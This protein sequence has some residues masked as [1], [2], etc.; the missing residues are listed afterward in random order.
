MQVY[1]ISQELFGSV[2]FPGN[3]VP[4]HRALK[5]MEDGQAANLSEISL[6]THNGTHVDA[7]RHF[8]SDG[9]TIDRMDLNRLVGPCSVI[10]FE[11]LLTAAD[12][13]RLISGRQQRILW[14]GDM[15]FGVDAARE[16]VRAGVLLVGVESQTVGTDDCRADVHRT[17]LNH[18]LAI[19]EGLR[20]GG[21]EEGD[22]LL[23]A[24]P[25]N[26]GGLEGAPCRAVLI[27][28]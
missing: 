17:L 3:P 19:V 5:R 26:L 11:G 20:L 2:V 27:R 12:A 18:E 28:P 15:A 23:C 21:V 25:V 13:A 10:A 16:F 24:A 4:A 1:D 22:Y 6:C 7:P 8:V 14:K 9:R